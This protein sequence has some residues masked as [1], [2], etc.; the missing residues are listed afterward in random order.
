MR[1]NW[2]FFVLPVLFCPVLW[3]AVKFERRI[4]WALQLFHHLYDMFFHGDISL[5]VR[6][7]QVS[8]FEF[9]DILYHFTDFS[10]GCGSQRAPDEIQ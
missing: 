8:S 10:Y 5:T 2:L 7:C 3:G 6:R 1:A 4:I 9:Y